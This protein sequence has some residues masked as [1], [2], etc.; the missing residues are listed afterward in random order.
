MASP[1]RTLVQRFDLNYRFAR[2][3]DR[4]FAGKR[5]SSASI[6]EVGEKRFPAGAVSNSATTQK[7]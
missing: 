6:G 4:G 2:D 3:P 5:F 7:I 1:D